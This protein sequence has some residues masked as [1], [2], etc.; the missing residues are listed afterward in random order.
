MDLK[1]SEES[2]ALVSVFKE[3]RNTI[4]IYTEDTIDDREFYL[5]LYKRLLAGTSCVINDI[6]PLGDCD[7]VV[8]ECN[9]G[10]DPRGL[11]IIDG[12]IYLIY[13]PKKSTQNLHVHNAYC[14]ENLIID[15]EAYVALIHDVVCKKS[16]SEYRE[17]LDVDNMFKGIMKPLIEFF[18]YFALEKKYR[19]AFTLKNIYCFCEQRTIPNIKLDAITNELQNIKR[20]LVPAYISDE[21]F[22]EELKRM[23]SQFPY[24]EETLLKI[25]SGKDYIIPFMKCY[26]NNKLGIKIGLPKEGWKHM[27]ARNCNL[28]CFSDLKAKMLA[29]A[30]KGQK[31]VDDGVI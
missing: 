3:Y 24:S 20:K 14:I 1:Y 8:R 6:T 13:Q 26:A 7:A 28:D 21:Q 5:Q 4:N 2:Q 25:V 12:D 30:K 31:I 18:F 27:M 19:N 11:Y 22:N 10:S 15:K 16:K 17:L 23:K 29:L 9:K